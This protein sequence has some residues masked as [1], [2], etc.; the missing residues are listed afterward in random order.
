MNSFIKV[1]VHIHCCFSRTPDG[2]GIQMKVI[3]E[4]MWELEDVCEK[5]DL[6]R[7]MTA[8]RL[9]LTLKQQ[10]NEYVSSFCFLLAQYL[11]TYSFSHNTKFNV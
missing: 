9:Y 11:K 2:I 5:L 7:R 3:D 6:Q 1:T 8:H 4:L 10:K